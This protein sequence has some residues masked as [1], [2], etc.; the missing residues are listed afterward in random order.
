MLAYNKY[1]YITNAR[2]TEYEN[3]FQSYSDNQIL[4]DAVN[5]QYRVDENFDGTTDYSIDYPDFNFKEFLSNLV[6]RWEYKPGSTLYFVWSQTRNHFKDNGSFN[7][8][9]NTH[10][11]FYTVPQ[12]VILLKFTYR[13]GV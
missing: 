8:A 3:R 13:I 4:W 1:K 10:D 2:A 7:I 9:D 12:N 11:L 6:V 5:S